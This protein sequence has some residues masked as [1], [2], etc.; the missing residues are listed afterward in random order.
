MGYRTNVIDKVFEVVEDA[1]PDLKRTRTAERANRV[2]WR[3]LQEMVDNETISDDGVPFAVIKDGPSIPAEYGGAND[4]YELPITV[5][6]IFGVRGDLKVDASMQAYIDDMDD[7]LRPAIRAISGLGLTL[8]DR[9]VAL[10]ASID[11]GV[12]ELFLQQ[13]RPFY[14]AAWSMTFITGYQRG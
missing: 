10:D 5:Y 7:A 13:N 14:S 4:S 12:N 6:V 3:G 8:K 1:L 11:N 9:A 2:D